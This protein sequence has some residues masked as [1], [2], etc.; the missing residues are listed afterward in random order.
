M[1]I[2]EVTLSKN[3]WYIQLL[4]YV[5][6]RIPLYNNFCPIFWLTMLALILSPF[7]FFFKMLWKGIVILFKLISIPIEKFG[8]IIDSLTEKIEENA[9]VKAEEEAERLLKTIDKEE[10]QTYR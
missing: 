7:V 4:N 8:K 10:L 6:P 3:G 5:F 1:F 9:K 2:K